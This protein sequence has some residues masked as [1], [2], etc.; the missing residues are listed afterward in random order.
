MHL[1][2]NTLFQASLSLRKKKKHQSKRHTSDIKNLTEEHLLEAGCLSI[3]QGPSTFDKTQTISVG[4]T[5]PWGKRVKHGTKKGDKRTAVKDV[6]FKDRIGQEYAEWT[7][8]Y[9][10]Q[11]SRRDKW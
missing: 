5:N 1:V 2:S 6:E 11:R 3:V 8:E 9:A 4:P 10:Y 7:N